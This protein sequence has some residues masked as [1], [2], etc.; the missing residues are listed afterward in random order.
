MIIIGNTK[1]ESSGIIADDQY[2]ISPVNSFWY[3]LRKYFSSIETI[4]QMCKYDG[5]GAE[6]LKTAI[7]DLF[8]IDT[9]TRKLFQWQWMVL[10][11]TQVQKLDC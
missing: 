9:T 2:N 11:L 4:L 3:F 6:A 7:N 5:T 10:V 1:I 8:M